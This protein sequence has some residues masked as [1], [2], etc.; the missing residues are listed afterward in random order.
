MK[1]ILACLLSV[2]VFS[3]SAQN[4]NQLD[5]NGKRDGI[6]KKNFDGTNVL[7]F[8]GAFDHGK[9]IGLFKFYQN[10]N[11]KAVLTATREFFKNDTKASVKFFASNG[12][13]ISEGEMNGKMY[14]GEWKYYQKESNKLLT[15]EHYNDEGHLTGERLVYYKNGQISQ[16]ENYKNGKLEGLSVWYSEDNIVIKEFSYSNGELNG[17]SKIYDAKGQLITEG[18][19]KNGQ[20]DGVWKYYENG[21]ISE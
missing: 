20:K 12:K 6:W 18:F 1:Y 19:Y 13:L 5:E 7:R 4:I 9:E 8:E 3:V 15:L 11:G 14:V 21:K 2:L 16:K 10:I 17:P